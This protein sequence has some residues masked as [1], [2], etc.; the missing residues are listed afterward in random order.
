MKQSVKD[1]VKGIV[2]AI[3]GLTFEYNDIFRA[4]VKFDDI[5]FPVCLFLLPE[6]G[7]T[8]VKNGIM[9][10]NPDCVFAFCEM[11]DLDP[12]GEE[13]DV[14]F[15]QLKGFSYKFIDA[16]N[17]SGLFKPVAENIPYFQEITKMDACVAWHAI[18]VKLE[19][20]QGECF[21]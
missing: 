12:E 20:I 15:E 2:E 17:K 1:K 21:R 10:D 14:I 16:V 9:R 11:C 4:N 13:I 19:E 8:T 3:D 5:K 6:T 18:R 7:M